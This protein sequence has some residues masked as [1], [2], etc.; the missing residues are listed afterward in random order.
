[1]I[2]HLEKIVKNIETQEL[3][4]YF[5]QVDLNQ[6]LVVESIEE[7]KKKFLIGVSYFRENFSTN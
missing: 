6:N 4:N 7:I 1:M 3:K 5:Q 2:Y